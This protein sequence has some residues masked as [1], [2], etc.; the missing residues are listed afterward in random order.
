MPSGADGVAQWLRALVLL[1]DLGVVSS[2][3]IGR[4]INACGTSSRASG[5]LSGLWAQYICGHKFIFSSLPLPYVRSKVNNKKF[6]D[7]SRTE[8]EKPLSSAVLSQR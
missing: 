2:A 7:K 3:H 1:E 4:F 6:L 5:A 8:N